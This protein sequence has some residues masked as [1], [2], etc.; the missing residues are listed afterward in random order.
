MFDVIIIGAGAAG[1]MAG[2]AVGSSGKKVLILERSEKVGKKLAITGGGGCNFTNFNAGYQHYYSQNPKFV[3]SALTSYSPKDLVSFFEQNSIQWLEKKDGQLFCASSAK[4][5]VELLLTKCV[6]AKVAIKTST[7][8]LKVEKKSAFE[9]TTNEGFFEA[10]KLVIATGGMSFPILGASGFGYDI[11]R[12]FG[13]NIV[14][15]NPALTPFILGDN[16]AH[17]KSISGVA[18]TAKAKVGKKEF[19]GDLLFTHFGLSGPLALNLSLY[20][21]ENEPIIF[22]FLPNLEVD[23]IDI[24]RESGKKELKTILQLMLPKSFLEALFPATILAKKIADFKD[25]ELRSMI[26]HLQ[27]YTIIPQGIIGYDKAEITRGGVDTKEV[28]SSTMESK[29]QSGLYFIGEVLDVSGEL[30][31]YNLQWAFSSAQKLEFV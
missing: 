23:L 9:I 10:E 30:G 17:F 26:Q 28:N 27:N 19:C 22:D 18:L 11:A 31:G 16:Y 6:Q 3:V 1:L 21:H 12:Q 20:W 8:I 14:S 13:H 29:L 24:K 5:I 15:L 7:T 4:D 2:M 25:A